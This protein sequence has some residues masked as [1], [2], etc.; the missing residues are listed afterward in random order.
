L[1]TEERQLRIVERLRASPF[2]SLE[3]LAGLVGTSV[4][5]VRRDVN[6]LAVEGVL[7]RTHGDVRRR[8]QAAGT[9]LPTEA[10]PI[11]ASEHAAEKLA[12]ARTCARLIEPGQTVI[13]DAG[14]T[15]H[16]VARQLEAKSPHIITNSLPVAA[17]FYGAQKLE[18]VVSG[19]TIYPRLGVLVGPLAVEAFGRI[20]ADVAIMSGGGI[21]VEGVSNSHALLIE[22]QRAMIAAARRIV[23]CFDHSKFGRHSLLHL[24]DLET[25]D[26]LVTDAAAPAALVREFRRRGVE[27]VVAP[28]T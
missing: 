24:C 10:R 8:E 2:A 6:Q 1:T 26:T 14:T 28:A 4:S 9:P 27:V 22:I 21:A 13:I 20:R 16:E 11:P 19:G 18:V 5:T 25:I 17:H 12:I 7:Q 23:F 3:E 15:C